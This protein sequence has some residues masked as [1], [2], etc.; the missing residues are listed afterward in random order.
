M[1]GTGLVLIC[2]FMDL[3][4]VS[5]HEKATKKD[6]LEVYQNCKSTTLTSPFVN[7]AEIL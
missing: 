5:V 6:F 2:L 3:N 7:K 4:V 1:A